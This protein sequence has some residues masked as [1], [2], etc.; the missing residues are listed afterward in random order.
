M[1]RTGIGAS[2]GALVSAVL[3]LGCCLPVGLLGAVGAAGL[4]TVLAPLRPW[5]M[6]LAAALLVVGVFQVR[7]GIRCGARHSRL[8]MILLVIAAAL[9][10]LLMVF[11]QAVAGW[12]ADLGGK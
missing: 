2:V 11:P 7:A 12:L 4:A 1:K 10:V 5:L 3:T 8:G 9:L 6:I